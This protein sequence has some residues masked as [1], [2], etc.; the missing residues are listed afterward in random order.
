M[1]IQ[2]IGVIGAGTMGSGIAQI[3]AVAGLQVTMI[4]VSTASLQRGL[5]AITSSLDRLVQKE[6]L[7]AVEKEQALARI[8]TT[9]SYEELKGADLV[10]EAATENL[11]LKMR[12][13][14]EIERVVAR[15]TLIASNT[16][17]IS[18]TQLAAVLQRPGR[19]IGMHSSTPCL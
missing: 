13:L 2:Q 6:K 14:R 7:H 15:D 12:I 8:F 11:E 4:D 16:S 17:S 18:I 1:T 5:S 19:C 3:S 10:I 9:T